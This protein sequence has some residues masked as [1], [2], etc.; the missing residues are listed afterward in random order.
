VIWVAILLTLA[1]VVQSSALATWLRSGLTPDLLLI[2]T[3][4]YGG[5]QGWRRGLAAG[6]LGGFLGS[7]VS[8]A[9]LGVYLIRMGGLGLGAGLAG[10]RFERTSPLLPPALVGVGTMAAA[11][12][13]TAALQAAGWLVPLTGPAMIELVLQAAMNAGIALLLLPLIRRIVR[14]RTE[15]ALS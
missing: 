13:T 14:T 15:E 8:V 7:L 12:V 11:V 5:L 9:P 4:L 2:V 3:V 10:G 6:L 1:L